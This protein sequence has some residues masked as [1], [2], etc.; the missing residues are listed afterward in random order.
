MSFY[1]LV[2][3]VLVIFT[4]SPPTF[5]ICIPCFFLT[6]FYISLHPGQYVLPKYFWIMWPP[7]KA[8]HVYQGLYFLRQL[9]LP[10]PTANRSYSSSTKRETVHS[11]LHS[12]IWSVLYLYKY[13]ACCH[14]ICE[15]ILKL[16]CCV[17]KIFCCSYLL[18]LVFKVFRP[19]LFYS[20]SWAFRRGIQDICSI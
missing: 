10:F 2:E 20:G 5:L 19:I 14:N 1:N 16:P 13:C 3:H 18:L 6:Q 17:H 11:P 4:L 15:F 12:G 9:T 7:T 8:L